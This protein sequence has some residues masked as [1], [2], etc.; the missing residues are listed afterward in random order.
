M[1]KRF[2]IKPESISIEIE[3]GSILADPSKTIPGGGGETTPIGGRGELDAAQY[4]S[5]LWN[6]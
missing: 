2:Y 1:M 6:D 3:F 5:N 4:R